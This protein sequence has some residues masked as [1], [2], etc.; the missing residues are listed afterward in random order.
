MLDESCIHDDGAR[1]TFAFSMDDAPPE[2]VTVGNDVLACVLAR[3]HHLRRL[4]W[5]FLIASREQFVD[6]VSVSGVGEGHLEDRA[7]ELAQACWAID[8]DTFLPSV[9]CFFKT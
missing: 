1:R 4:T 5:R 7:D 2:A 6:H 9:V 8:L 3:V